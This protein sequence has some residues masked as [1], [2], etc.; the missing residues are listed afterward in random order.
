MLHSLPIEVKE[1]L[2]PILEYGLREHLFKVLTVKELLWGYQDEL[3]NILSKFVTIPGM[4]NGEF[5]FLV[6]V[7]CF[8]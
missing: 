6:D 4:P 7:G 2:S 5:G 1:L 8:T 3:L